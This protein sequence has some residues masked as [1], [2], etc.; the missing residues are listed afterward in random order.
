MKIPATM[1][2]RFA[3][4]TLLL[5]VIFLISCKQADVQE[6]MQPPSKKAAPTDASVNDPAKEVIEKKQ[7]T[8]AMAAADTA[9]A[10]Q[11]QTDTTVKKEQKTSNVALNP[12]KLPAT[13]AGTKPAA[14]K[15]VETTAAKPMLPKPKPA[16][17]TFGPDDPRSGIY[18]SITGKM[19]GMGDPSQTASDAYKY[20]QGKHPKALAGVGLP[21]DKFGLIDWMAIVNEKIIEPRGSLKKGAPEIPP[22]DMNVLIES[23]G[24]FVND[25][26]FPHKAHT[27]WLKCENC[28]TGI[29][30]MAKGKN[31]MTMQGIVEGKW[32]GRCHGKVAFP[33]TDCNRCHQTPKNSAEATGVAVKK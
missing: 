9:L 16:L 32:C 27:Y 19:A 31:N 2:N 5:S 6:Q 23:K 17:P 33:L 1:Y 28:H 22:F 7:D 21:K 8:P 24:D 20:G 11:S 13:A 29:F 25:V 30:I 18:L 14:E 4:T 12:N 10:K 15:P 26:L 3:L